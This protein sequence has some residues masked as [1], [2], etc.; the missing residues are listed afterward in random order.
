MSWTNFLILIFIIYILYYALILFFDLFI[1]P[2]ATTGDI[3]EDELFFSQTFAPELI[4]PVEEPEASTVSDEAD[5]RGLKAGLS[6]GTIS[7]SG[8]VGL[9]QLFSLAKNNLIEHTRAIPY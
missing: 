1:S 2:K 9:K 4:T 8:G 7:S 3:A 5:A 6:S